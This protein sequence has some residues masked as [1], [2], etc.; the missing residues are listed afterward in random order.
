MHE[1]TRPNT[2]I[3]ISLD[4]EST[5]DLFKQ[6][7]CFI[8]R[9]I[10]SGE[11]SAGDK[12]PS[13]RQLARTLRISRST[14]SAAYAELHRLGLIDNATHA[15][16]FVARRVL[17]HRQKPFQ[18]NQRES[19]TAPHEQLLNFAPDDNLACAAMEIQAPEFAES[20]FIP[21]HLLPQKKWNQLLRKRQLHEAPFYNQ[22]LQDSNFHWCGRE[23]YSEVRL[24]RAL[25]AYLER[26][27][28]IETAPDQIVVFGNERQALHAMT[29]VLFNEGDMAVLEDPCSPSAK[30]LFLARK[31]NLS[32]IAVDISGL[33][34]HQLQGLENVKLIYTAPSNQTPLGLTMQKERR[35]ALLDYAGS[36]NAV[37]LE[38]DCNHELVYGSSV[39]PALKSADKENRI[40]YFS[41][42]SRSLSPLTDLAFVVAP[43][44]IAHKLVE[45]RSLF[46]AS[47]SPMEIDV[48]AA[49][50]ELGYLERYFH[51]LRACFSARRR[52]LIQCLAATFG[53]SVYLYPGAMGNTIC[54]RFND[55]YPQDRLVQSALSTGL[56]AFDASP[57]FTKDAG[58]RLLFSLPHLD[59]E[60]LAERVFAF[61]SELDKSVCLPPVSCTVP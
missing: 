2:L 33:L 46:G 49:M 20:P 44:S 56:P 6:I 41:S 13:T 48:V 54:A 51:G 50:L 32:H 17:S 52:R 61:K 29:T 10:E 3:S 9:R 19:K 23:Q 35:E 25:A 37:I 11:L 7:V 43:A 47:A 12:L 42:F 4:F 26:T 1:Y 15:G 38:N 30:A 60:T 59:E 28:G 21:Q 8:R 31:A 18:E 22:P 40:V 5:T 36:S 57:F 39:I 53:Q 27:R 24:R 45:A 34:V 16:T 14:T 58:H 55:A